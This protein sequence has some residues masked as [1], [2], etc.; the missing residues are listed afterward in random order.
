MSDRSS[1]LAV[2]GRRRHW[3]TADTA[4]TV[5]WP[6]PW[7]GADWTGI[8]DDAEERIRHLI[9][10]VVE[11]LVPQGEEGGRQL[12]ELHAALSIR[13]VLA[14][15]AQVSGFHNPTAGQLALQIG[16]PLL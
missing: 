8:G 3:C 7:P 4:A 9:G 12:V 10:C 14:L 13:Q 16:V 6:A 11:Q 15:A 1:C 5:A 2:S